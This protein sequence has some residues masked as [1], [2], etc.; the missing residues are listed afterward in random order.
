MK[1]NLVHCQLLARE[2]TEPAKMSR[3]KIKVSKT[4][5][6]TG[7]KPELLFVIDEKPFQQ[8]IHL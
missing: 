6:S 3:P 1:K 8:F 5:G 2:R 4:T 7:A